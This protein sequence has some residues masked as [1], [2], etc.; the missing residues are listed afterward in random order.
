MT[1]KDKCKIHGIS[2]NAVRRRMLKGM[3]EQEALTR[4]KPKQ[5]YSCHPPYKKIVVGDQKQSLDGHLATVTEYINSSH[6]IIQFPDGIYKR[7]TSQRWRAGEFTMMHY[8]FGK[9]PS[10]SLNECAA[11]YYFQQICFNLPTQEDMRLLGF[12]NGESFDMYHPFYKI[13]IEYDGMGHTL[14]KDHKKN[15]G[16]QN[17]GIAIYRLREKQCEIINDG[18]SYNY[19]GLPTSWL[20]QQYA[21][22]LQNLI[23]DIC[24][25]YDIKDIPIVDFAEDK[26]DIF[27]LYSLYYIPR[28]S[29]RSK[30]RR[31]TK[32]KNSALREEKYK[33]IADFIVE[34][35]DMTYPEIAQYLHVSESTVGRTAVKY[36]IKRHNKRC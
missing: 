15:I 18:I 16:C 28:E 13:A 31:L 14:K 26:K 32:E 6:V 29:Q 20:S 10:H 1:L 4:P 33:N 24:T 8:K 5:S 34:H 23:T 9:N 35:S 2:Y 17:Q 19:C 36:N 11:Y 7:T 21:T 12:N 25:K 22:T 3:S 30:E 27:A